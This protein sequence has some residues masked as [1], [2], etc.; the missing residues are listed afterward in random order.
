MIP[1]LGLFSLSLGALLSLTACKLSGSGSTSSSGGGGAGGGASTASSNP[2]TTG[3]GAGSTSGSGTTTG[4]GIDV[5]PCELDPGAMPNPDPRC[6]SASPGQGEAGTIGSGPPFAQ[7]VGAGATGIVGAFLDPKLEKVIVATDGGANTS[8]GKSIQ[9]GTVYSVDPL[10]GDRTIV[11]GYYDD[12]QNGPSLVGKG[13]DLGKT[14]AIAYVPDGRYLVAADESGPVYVDPKTGDREFLPAPDPNDSECELAY[15]ITGKQALAVADDTTSYWGF[16]NKSASAYTTC[17][18]TGTASA[19]WG[20]TAVKGSSCHVVT[21][22]G[23]C[24]VSTGPCWESPL[25]AFQVVGNLVYATD[26]AAHLWSINT[27]DGTRK[28]I[29]SLNN[30]MLGTGDYPVGH[31][32]LLVLGKTAWTSG[33]LPLAVDIPTGNRTAHDHVQ[34]PFLSGG[35]FMPHPSSSTVLLVAWKF[36]VGLYD[37]L[38]DHSMLLSR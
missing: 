28:R 23:A 12:P 3:S 6:G 20:L 34:G 10:T 18:S 11:S 14:R 13:S 21:S 25:T 33:T 15:Q 5:I 24:V 32:S 36:A 35:Y 9:H 37:P 31:D 30:P 1:R 38:S 29:S 8:F 19:S 27:A 7:A 16:A 17:D 4:G 2:D 22:C 26:E